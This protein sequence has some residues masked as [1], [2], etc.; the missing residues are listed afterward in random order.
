MI[1]NVIS[2]TVP[3]AH[4]TARLS[5]VSHSVECRLIAVRPQHR[6]PRL[7]TGLFIRFCS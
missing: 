6:P 4:E 2:Y 5:D 3:S 7:P 1:L